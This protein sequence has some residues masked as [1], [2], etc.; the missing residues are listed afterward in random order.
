MKYFSIRLQLA[1]SAIALGIL[2]LL[3]QLGIQFYVLRADIVQRI[4]RHEFRQL[5]DFAEY[6]DEKLEESM[7]MLTSITPNISAQ[8]LSNTQSLQSTLQ[9]ESALLTV[10]DDLY[11]FNAQGL[12]LVDWPVKPGRR[13]LD[14][15]E[16]DYIQEVVKTHKTVIS[17]P[18][19]GKA[20]KQ[21]TVVVAAPILDEHNRL[22][23]IVGG[24]LNLNKPNLLGTIA[25]RKNGATGYYYLVTRDR[26]RIAHPDPSMILKTVPPNSTNRAFEEAMNGFEGTLEGRTTRGLKALFTF[27]KLKTTDWIVGSV[28]PTEEAFA[29][30]TYLYHRMLLVTLLLLGAVIPLLWIFAANLVK[31]LG[32][33]AQAMH[34]TAARMRD[35]QSVEPIP[36]LGSQEIHTVVQAFNEFMAARMRAECLL[37]QARDEAQAANASKSN[38]LANMSHEIR[39]PMNGIVGMTELCLQT[40]TTDEQRSYLEMVQTSAKSL[41]AVINDILDF[42]KI[43]ARKLDL[44]PH[45][46]SVHTLVRQST[47]ALSLRAV[48]KGLE[49]VSDIASDV[50]E[51]VVGDALRLQQVLTNLLGNAIKFTAQGEVIL[52]VEMAKSPPSSD[53]VWLQF[54]IKDTG[55]GISKDK[56]SL[57]FDIFTQ[58]DSSTARRF[59]GS[60]LGLAISRSL[61]E[62]MGGQ[63]TVQSELGQGSTFSFTTHLGHASA[64]RVVRGELSTQLAGETVLVVDDNASSRRILGAN[65]TSIGLHAVM[66]EGVAQ[67]LH[68]PQTQDAHYALIDV[69]LPDIDGYALATELRKT[70]S[71]AQLTIIMMGALSEQTPQEL[72]QSHDIQGFLVK[73]IDLHEL[74]NILNRWSTTHVQLP[75]VPSA[76]SHETWSPLGARVL[77]AEDTPINQ[78]LA[79]IILT[80]MGCE[81]TV[82]NNGVEA[83]EAF[84]EGVFDLVLMDIQMPEMGGLEATKAI[85]ERECAQSCRPTPIIAV[86]ANALKGD[87]ERYLEAGMNGYVSKPISV[88]ALK[89]EMQRLLRDGVVAPR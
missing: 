69:G 29:P 49:L 74:V 37:S 9:R 30:I 80:R 82:A 10:F 42:S 61:V 86:T 70:R 68:L 16:R 85:R 35:G 52:S 79:T 48:E 25:T 45:E 53:G 59:G 2:L 56:Q 41:L 13:M 36:E 60:G 34:D 87:R 26:V 14:M 33:L 89:S 83:L 77:L 63:I 38:F 22:L 46:F 73:P 67:A 11:V 20:T 3:A 81:V 76:P 31:P 57:I 24:V 78:T 7:D 75:P 23:G 65:L 58:A 43:E 19:L 32:Q 84:A 12:L 47:R 71:S 27:K 88:E 8:Q 21:P 64:V 1:L 39:T 62:M 18:I 17:K 54:H 40:R 51:L 5:T 28:I 72:L 66:C 50:P 55:I 44:D 4:E 15:S 6:L